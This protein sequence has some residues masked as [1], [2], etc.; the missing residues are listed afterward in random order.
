[1]NLRLTTWVL[2]WLA[3][4]SSN[5]YSPSP[6]RF[7]SGQFIRPCS[8]FSWPIICCG[9][10]YCSSPLETATNCPQDCSGFV[11]PPE[12]PSGAHVEIVPNLADVNTCVG[13]TTGKL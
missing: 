10:H 5:L 13:T 1:M 11:P 7:A 4:A 9:D 8:V 6:L 3:L 2:F 12:E